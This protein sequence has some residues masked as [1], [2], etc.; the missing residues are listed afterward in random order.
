[1]PIL[2]PP[3]TNQDRNQTSMRLE[4]ILLTTSI[5][6]TKSNRDKGS[7]CLKLP[8]AFEKAHSRAIHQNREEHSGDTKF[9]PRPQSPTETTYLK[10]VEQEF[11]I[12]SIIA[13][14]HINFA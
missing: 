9:N 12:D 8:R 10:H 4:I 2:A 7:P 13:L 6:E 3:T 11:P 14:L 5:M 1:M